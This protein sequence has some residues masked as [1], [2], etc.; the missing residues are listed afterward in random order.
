[1]SDI[2]YVLRLTDIPLWY[3]AAAVGLTLIVWAAS[4][5]WDAGILAGCCFFILAVTVLSRTRFAGEHFE[6][7]LF[8]SWSVPRL[9]EQ[10][11]WNI[12]GF[13]PIGLLAGRR[14]S[15]RVIPAAAAFSLLIEALQLVSGRGLF[16][17]DDIVHNALGAA[18][19][20][21]LWLLLRP[22]TRPPARKE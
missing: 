17:F 7:R 5:K 19:G 12:L 14:L 20:Y 4:R 3:Y 2:D 1:M 10:I 21:G 16:E 13:I 22:L 11:L 18:L 15:W 9:R 8:W 6:P